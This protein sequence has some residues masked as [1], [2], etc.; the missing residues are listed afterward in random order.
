MSVNVEL[1]PPDPPELFGHA[2]YWRGGAISL[3]VEQFAALPREAQGWI[4]AA[5]DA[6]PLALSASRAVVDEFEESA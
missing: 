1:L 5:K 6:Q 4:T 3:T 2:D